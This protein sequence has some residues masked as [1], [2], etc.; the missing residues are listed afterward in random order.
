MQ[1]FF[2][3]SVCLLYFPPNIS[4]VAA[5]S[6]FLAMLPRDHTSWRHDDEIETKMGMKYARPATAAT[7]A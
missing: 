2:S 1:I 4:R 7:E 3:V 5:P 6:F